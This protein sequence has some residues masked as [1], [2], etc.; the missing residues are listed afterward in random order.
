MAAAP[1]PPPDAG[2]G[3]G[4]GGGM[5]SPAP[6]VNDAGAAQTVKSIMTIVANARMIAQSV[7]GATPE[8]QQINDLVQRIMAKVKQQQPPQEPQAPPV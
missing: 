4:P 7:P 1:I 8:V 5:A 3:P 2:Q 6:A